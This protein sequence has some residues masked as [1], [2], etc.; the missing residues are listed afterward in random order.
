MSFWSSRAILHALQQADA[1]LRPKL[2]HA[3]TSDH[4][5]LSVSTDSRTITPGQCFIALRG[6]AFDAHA[7]LSKAIDAG[8]AMI[9]AEDFSS[10]PETHKHPA[11]CTLISVRSTRAALLS[12]ANAYRRSLTNTTV[13]AVCGS[14]GK[15][16]TVRM[17]EGVLA[18]YMPGTASKKSFNNDVGVPITI[19]SARSTDR[20]LICEVGTNAPGEI[21]TLARVVQP[22]LAV[23]TS[24]GREHLEKLIDLKGVA[25]EESDILRSIKPAGHAFI[26]SESPELNSELASS[27]LPE[28]LAAKNITLQSFGRTADADLHLLRFA[29]HRFSDGAVGSRFTAETRSNDG[30]TTHH[31]FELPIAGEH[32]AANALGVIAIARTLGLSDTQIEHALR[33]VRGAEMR[34]QTHRLTLPASAAT[35][36]Q[37]EIVNDAYNAN[38]DSMLASLRAFAGLFAHAPRRVFIMGEMFEL[39]PSTQSL[40]ESVGS[41]LATNRSADLFITVGPMARKAA[42]RAASINP[43]LAS[44]SVEALTDETAEKILGALRANDAVLLKGSRRAG[45]ERL[46]ARFPAPSSPTPKPTTT[47]LTTNPAPIPMA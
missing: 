17:L 11:N 19:L 20:F 30:A 8:A 23:I 34:W 36:G 31:T 47:T 15:T 39:G 42:E 10:L 14:N 35:P 12:L 24:I 16:T 37:I 6:E 26:T 43:N 18:S 3:P 9:I 21:A 38:P 13:I 44:L 1:D 40:H 4:P 33:Q 7:F 22:D 32:N 29:H 2:T 45:L 5:V 27:R 28:H 46:L 41:A 25:K